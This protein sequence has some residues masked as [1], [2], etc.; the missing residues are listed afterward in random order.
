MPYQE[1][2][3][4]L[5]EAPNPPINYGLTTEDVRC[6]SLCFGWEDAVNESNWSRGTSYET[7]ADMVRAEPAQFLA[8]IS[9][10]YGDDYYSS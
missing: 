8:D 10:Y 2:L 7:V 3:N 9:E 6:L 4:A 5:L 1:I